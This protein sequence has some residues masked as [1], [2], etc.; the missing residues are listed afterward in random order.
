[1]PLQRILVVQ[2]NRSYFGRPALARRFKMRV[3]NFRAEPA[4]PGWQTTPKRMF[5]AFNPSTFQFSSATRAN[6]IGEMLAVAEVDRDAQT[7]GA[8]H[9]MTRAA[10]LSVIANLPQIHA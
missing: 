6:L 10:I 7:S 4:R 3:T 9:G 1:M 2:V 8:S 5:A